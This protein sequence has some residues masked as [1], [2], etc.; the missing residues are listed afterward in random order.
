MI[1]NLPTWLSS[2]EHIKFLLIACIIQVVSCKDNNNCWACTKYA[3]IK[4]GQGQCPFVLRLFFAKISTQV[5]WL[6]RRVAVLNTFSAKN[7][8]QV[9]RSNGTTIVFF[10]VIVTG[11]QVRQGKSKRYN[12][13]D[14]HRQAQI[15]TGTLPRGR[16]LGVSGSQYSCSVS[17]NCDL[18]WVGSFADWN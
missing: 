13:T 1:R 10:I 7:W 9:L 17:A 12:S 5:T 3:I 14:P 8:K 15:H 16:E 2:L 18:R 6:H 11:I 4:W